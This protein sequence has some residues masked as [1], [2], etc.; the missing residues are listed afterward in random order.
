[1]AKLKFYA[2]KRGRKPGI[3]SQWYGENGAEAQVKGYPGAIYRGFLSREE[4][5][6]FLKNGS[7]KASLRESPV[8]TRIPHEPHKDKIVIYTDGGCQNNPGPGGYGVVIQSG[9]ERKELSG[10]YRLT[11]NNRMELMACIVGL[12]TLPPRSSVILHSDSKYVID[13]LSKGWAKK[14]WENSWMRNNKERAQ[15]PDLWRKRLVLCEKHDVEFLWVKGH[16][17]NRENERCDELATKASSG[18]NW[19]IDKVYEDNHE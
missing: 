16:A 2:V 10:G 11:T 15:N 8:S 5:M 4:A 19:L 14:W 3:Y 13:A 17:G 6:S 9:K 12:Q 18:T 1:M 7:Y